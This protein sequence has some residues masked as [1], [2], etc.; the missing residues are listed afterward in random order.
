MGQWKWLISKTD[1]LLIAATLAAVVMVSVRVSEYLDVRQ[2]ENPAPVQ[3]GHWER[4]ASGGHRLGPERAAVTVVEFADFQCPFCAQAEA[5]LDSVRHEDSANVA[6][7]FHEYPLAGHPEAEPAARAA[8]CAGSQG[9]FWQFHDALYAHQDDL[10]RK[11]WDKLAE[12]A[13]VNDL[14]A[15]HKCMGG[16]DSLKAVRLDQAAGAEL[17]VTATPTFLVNGL[18]VVGFP[19][20]G[21]LA[22]MVERALAKSQSTASVPNP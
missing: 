18:K 19:G 16:G 4:Y 1:A 21:I 8:E 10:P 2:A 20:K 22:A 5:D 6:L 3:V 7:V 9:V 11:A 15:F 12:G 13:G 17:G 14:D